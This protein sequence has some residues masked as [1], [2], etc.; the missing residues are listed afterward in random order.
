MKIRWFSRHR[1]NK[2]PAGAHRSNAPYR[3]PAPSPNRPANRPANL[4]VNLPAWMT[5]PTLAD[6]RPGRV[7]WL[8]PAQQWRANGGHW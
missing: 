7:G 8:T 5:Q 3:P 4:P 2:P 1:R 6:P